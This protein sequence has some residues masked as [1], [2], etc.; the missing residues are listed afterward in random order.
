MQMDPG[1]DSGPILKL[2]S[3]DLA[4]DETGGSLHDRLAQLGADAL[5]DCVRQLCAGAAPVPEPQPGEGVTYARKLLKAEAEIDWRDPAPLIERRI[6][7]FNPWPVAFCD[8]DGERTRIWAAAV[9]PRDH[10]QPP[11][12]VLHAGRGGIDIACGE[13][14]LRITQLQRPGGRVI[15]AEEY[16]HGRALPENLAG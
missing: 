13:Q 16:L 7:A 3:C 5:L 11:G 4:P 2:V 14:I 8:I 6:R 1:L 10:R 9:L 15:T 12:A